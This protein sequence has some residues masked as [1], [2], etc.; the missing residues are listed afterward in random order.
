V[1]HSFKSI[2][3]RSVGSALLVGMM[4]QPSAALADVTAL[5]ATTTAEVDLTR[6]IDYIDTATQSWG[7][8]LSALQAQAHVYQQGIGEGHSAVY[9]GWTSAS[10][11]SFQIHTDGTLTYPTCC[12]AIYNDS[13]FVTPD[14]LYRFSVDTD[15]VFHLDY[16]I[17]SNQETGDGF[18]DILLNGVH[19]NY[20]SDPGGGNVGFLE[21]NLLAG[22]TYTVSVRNG[23]GFST[24]NATNSKEYTLAGDFGFAINALSAPGGVPEPATWLMLVAGFGAA[25]ALMRGRR[26]VSQSERTGAAVA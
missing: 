8:P 12:S 15:S 6:G 24:T 11:G 10:V 20:V 18:F 4:C 23:S 26:A 25:G 7:V 21:Y 17:T 19:M 14:W 2:A 9:A 1:G 13:S 5:A 16:D 22:Q 3:L